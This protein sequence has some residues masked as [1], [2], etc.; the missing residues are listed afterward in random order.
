[1]GRHDKWK[2]RQMGYGK[3]ETRLYQ[4]HDDTFLFWSSISSG[5]GKEA[6]PSPKEQSPDLSE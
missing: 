2:K 1:M 6:L 5:G 3:A 4:I